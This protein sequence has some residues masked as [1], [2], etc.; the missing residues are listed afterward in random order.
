[1]NSDV[2]YEMS[3]ADKVG[4]MLLELPIYE[5]HVSMS[6]EVD[7]D[8]KDIIQRIR[9]EKFSKARQVL[10]ESMNEKSGIKKELLAMNPIYE[11]SKKVKPENREKFIKT[12]KDYID[13]NFL[14]NE[15]CEIIFSND[16]T[17]LKK[18]MGG[19]KAKTMGE[20]MGFVDSDKKSP[21][22]DKI[23][24]KEKIPVKTIGWNRS[25]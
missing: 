5:L 14:N 2:P 11:L 21:E 18:N 25:K 7:A 19:I 10:Q 8:I 24:E 3:Y 12:V 4:K 6:E 15:G 20:K 16:Y 17:K 13:K 22:H 9:D 1:M 23:L